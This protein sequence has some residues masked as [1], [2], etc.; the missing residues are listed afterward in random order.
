MKFKMKSSSDDLSVIVLSNRECILAN[1]AYC[2]S[3]LTTNNAKTSSGNIKH[4]QLLQ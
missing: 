2:K 1:Y 4:I 3:V